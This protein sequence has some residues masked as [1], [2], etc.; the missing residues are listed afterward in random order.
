[1][2][3][4]RQAFTIQT[5]IWTRLLLYCKLQLTIIPRNHLLKKSGCNTSFINWKFTVCF[6]TIRNI[7]LKSVAIC[8]RLCKMFINKV[9]MKNLTSK[10]SFHWMYTAQKYF[11]SIGDTFMVKCASLVSAYVLSVCRKMSQ[12]DVMST[13]NEMWCAK[14]HNAAHTIRWVVHLWRVKPALHAEK[15]RQGG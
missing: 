3:R 2:W 5:L 1:M 9:T 14:A 10:I 12:C 11:A 7:A 15:K 13:V 8:S 4:L 6:T